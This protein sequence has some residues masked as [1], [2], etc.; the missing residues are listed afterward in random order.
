MPAHQCERCRLATVPAD[1]AQTRRPQG[2][3]GVVQ[4][5]NPAQEVFYT[6]WMQALSGQ[7]LKPSLRAIRGWHLFPLGEAASASRTRPKEFDPWPRVFNL[8]N[9]CRGHG[10]VENLPPQGDEDGK[11]RLERA[12]VFEL[13]QQV[14]N[15]WVHVF[16]GASFQLAHAFDTMK[17]CRHKGMKRREQDGNEPE[18]RRLPAKIPLQQRASIDHSPREDFIGQ[19]PAGSRRKSLSLPRSAPP[20]PHVSLHPVR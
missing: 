12:R 1:S 11:A 16:V 7:R 10:Q 2:E 9:P 17:S 15:P 18:D 6:E 4:A 19:T 3:N 14:F 5:N 13:W 8:W 20:G